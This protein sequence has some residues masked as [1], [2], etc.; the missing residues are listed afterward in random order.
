MHPVST[1]CLWQSCGVWR[2]TPLLSRGERA[3]VGSAAALWR[4]V[5]QNGSQVGSARFR[6]VCPHCPP[7]EREMS[8][9]GPL[10]QHQRRLGPPVSGPW[11]SQ[12]GGG[13]V[14][15]ADSKLK[16]QKISR[17]REEPGVSVC[18]LYSFALS[19]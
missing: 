4:H 18:V 12:G 14:R 1:S 19:I 7:Q 13:E 6:W 8:A 11:S 10:E 15:Q 3:R 5:L 9:R 16:F 2:G 17:L